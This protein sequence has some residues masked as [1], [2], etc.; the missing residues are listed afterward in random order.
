MKSVIQTKLSNQKLSFPNNKRL[1]SVLSCFTSTL[2]A[3]TQSSFSSSDLHSNLIKTLFLMSYWESSI[4]FSN[5]WTSN[6]FGWFS[7]TSLTRTWFRLKIK[8]MKRSLNPFYIPDM[9]SIEQKWV[10]WIW[11]ICTRPAQQKG[12]LE[13]EKMAGRKFLGAPFLSFLNASSEGSFENLSMFEKL[14]LSWQV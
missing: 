12:F 3:L 5:M 11:D 4:I 13:Q 6:V 7:I 1:A 9:I 10:V 14:S 8:M 2:I